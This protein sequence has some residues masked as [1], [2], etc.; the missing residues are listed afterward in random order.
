MNY[1]PAVSPRPNKR[2][3]APARPRGIWMYVSGWGRAGQRLRSHDG[4]STYSIFWD[5]SLRREKG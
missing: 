1:K 2:T 5:G 4:R 3:M